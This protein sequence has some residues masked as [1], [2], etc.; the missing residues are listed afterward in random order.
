M[1]GAG[2][3][4]VGV[5]GAGKISDQYLANMA[6][7][8]DLD[9]RF[10]A[11]LHPHLARAQAERHGVPDSGTTEQ[12]L[13]RDDVEL[14]VNLTVPAAHAEVASA[15]LAAGKHVFNEKP[16][17]PDLASAEALIAQADAAGLRLGCAPDTFLG[18]GLQTMRRLLEAGRIGTPLT[19]SVVMQSGGPHLW[20]PNPDFLYQPGAGPLFDMGP[21]Y[22]T[23]LAQAFGPVARVAARGGTAAPTRVIGKGPRAGEE[24]P[25]A[26]PT[27]VAALYEFESGAVAQA[28]FSFDTP[29]E[30]MGVL[31]ITG[32][33][34][35]LVAPDPNTF[36]GEIRVNRGTAG[37]GVRPGHGRRTRS[38]HRGRGHGAR[39]P[40][41]A[42]PQHRCQ[43]RPA[44]P[45]RDGGHR[46]LDRDRH[47]RRGREPL[48]SRRRAPGGLGPDGAHARGMTPEPS[49]E[50][51]ARAHLDGLIAL[52][53]AEGWT[54]YTEDAERTYRALSGRGV[55]TLVALADERV[56]GAIQVQS[57]GVIQAHVSMLLIDGQWRG[58]QLGTRLLREGLERAGG[59]WLDI[60]TRTE[61]YYERLGA[62]R[63]LGYRLTREALGL[64]DAGAG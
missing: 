35:T 47:V 32:A 22:L 6:R 49:I 51:F 40:L 18:P 27:Y 55:T 14:I 13:A 33:E 42:R 17:A 5:V 30:R 31:E 9:V 20:H 28:T 2:P 11:D 16:I 24:I 56:V 45:R 59:L 60:R 37:V 1:S 48:R 50:P 43:A 19:A 58:H 62:S 8:P 12:A 36:A 61:G 38:R 15:A 52:V 23:A 57:D 26:V 21:Y 39:D 41:R 10:V 63:S 29:L 3:V 64:G 25:V 4:G 53:A 46:D 34:A 44:R 54:E 7:Y